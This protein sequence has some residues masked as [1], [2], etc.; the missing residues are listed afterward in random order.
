MVKFLGVTP[1]WDT[2]SLPYPRVSYSA[3][4]CL[5]PACG[6]CE[7]T[8][9]VPC[10]VQSA[11]SRAMAGRVGYSLQA[12]LL[13]CG[14]STCGGI[15]CYPINP[16]CL[17][18]WAPTPSSLLCSSSPQTFGYS[19]LPT[20][21]C[22][23]CYSFTPSIPVGF[24][25]IPIVPCVFSYFLFYFIGDNHRN[26][27]SVYIKRQIAFVSPVKVRALLGFLQLPAFPL[28]NAPYFSDSLNC[29][30]I[31]CVLTDVTVICGDSILFSFDRCFFHFQ[32]KYFNYS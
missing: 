3:S 26:C 18:F 31:L 28:E 29:S 24:C 19:I 27:F 17:L 32:G 9:D 30:V 6:E 1:S 16:S 12:L 13:P 7:E 23:K 14:D 2:G 10:D 15:C 8:Y 20:R 11:S 22:P 25:V 4:C 21:F 5:S